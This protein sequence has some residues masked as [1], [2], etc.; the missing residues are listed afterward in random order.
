MK[1]QFSTTKMQKAC[2]SERE[3][4]KEWGAAV[5]K[6]LKLRLAQLEAAATLADVAQ[7]PGARCHELAQDRKGQLAVDLAH[8]HR[9]IFV[10]D[11]DPVPRK[12][13]GGLDWSQVTCILILEIVDYH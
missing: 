4:A 1:I 13:D 12:P 10:P 7:M 6:K 3:M 11:H 5:A 8:P 9:L 2:C